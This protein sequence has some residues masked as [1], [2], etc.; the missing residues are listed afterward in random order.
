MKNISCLRYNFQNSPPSC[1]PALRF[2]ERTWRNAVIIPGAYSSFQLLAAFRRWPG[3]DLDDLQARG[4]FVW[5]WIDASHRRLLWCLGSHIV[6]G[7]RPTTFIWGGGI[8]LFLT[9]WWIAWRTGWPHRDERMV[10]TKHRLIIIAVIVGQGLERTVEG[11]NGIRRRKILL[12]RGFKWN[13]KRGPTG[14]RPYVV[15]LVVQKTEIWFWPWGDRM[16][17]PPSYVSYVFLRMFYCVD[18]LVSFK[19]EVISCV[20]LLGSI[21]DCAVFWK[22]SRFCIHG[23]FYAIKNYSRCEIRAS[24]ASEIP[25]SATTKGPVKY[26]IRVLQ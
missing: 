7:D 25:N 8:V 6:S 22:L 20:R 12:E 23:E 14:Y 16:P 19:Q 13:D 24:F 9:R 10:L 17:P 26:V 11:F 21:K 3:Y 4:D 5:R 18:R 1:P 2:P 15:V